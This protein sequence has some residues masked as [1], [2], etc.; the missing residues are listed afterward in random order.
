MFPRKMNPHKKGVG[1]EAGIERKTDGEA[2]VRLEEEKALHKNLGKEEDGVS[3]TLAAK[4][5][6]QQDFWGGREKKSD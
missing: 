1:L 4:N 2:M 5:H 3:E 6:E